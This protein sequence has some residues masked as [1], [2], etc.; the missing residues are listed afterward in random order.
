MSDAYTK[1]RDDAGLIDLDNWA[2]FSVSGSEATEAL[3]S[4]VGGNVL[5]LFEG[6][7]L[8]TLIPSVAGGVEA[9]VWIIATDDGFHVVAE[10]E[11]A[12]A[13]Q[14]ALGEAKEEFD[15]DYADIKDS[16]FHLVITGPSAEDIASEAFGDDIRSVA[17]LNAHELDNG[18]L[19]ARI[20]YFGEYELHLFGQ[21][22]NKET[23]Q[24]ALTD[25]AGRDIVTDQ[26]AFPVLM[27]EMRML[28]RARDIAPEASVFDAGLQWMVDFQKDN[29]R[30]KDAMDERRE[31]KGRNCILMVVDG[32]A[33]AGALEVEGETIGDLRSVYSSPTLGK[34][35]AL[36][37]IDGEL[38]VPGLVLQSTSGLV[39]TV[40]AP[41][42]L[43]KSVTNA[44]GASA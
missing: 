6:K 42:F 27:A 18:V 32:D 15:F 5:D 10:P 28:N 30:G 41:A 33:T 9:I 17:F 35:V 23:A 8:N 36:A 38:A 1:I 16:Q 20:G 29:L 13:I 22:D 39:E 2:R 14:S 4:I 21:T 43:S 7:A 37:Y 31:E 34:K 12:E 3:D 11:E 26:S 25:A 44:L 24:T 40:S 19:A